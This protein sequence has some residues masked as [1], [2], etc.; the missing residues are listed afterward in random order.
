MDVVAWSWAQCLAAGA[1]GHQGV[2]LSAVRDNRP[3]WLP[4]SVE[5]ASARRSTAPLDRVLAGAPGQLVA[6]DGE[7]GIGKSRLLA[8]LAERAAAAGCVVVGAAASEFEDDLPYAVWTEA[9]DAHL[10]EL[11]D[12]R[13]GAARP[14]LSRARWRR[15]CPRSPG[16]SGVAGTADRHALHRALR[17]LLER[18]AGARP[19]VLWLDDVHWADPGSV[20][21]LAALVRR[22]PAGAVLIAVAAREGLQPAPVA[23]ALAG[24]ARDGRVSHLALAPLSEAEA[25]ELV[26]RDVG[27][28]LRA[29]RRQPVLPRAARASRTA[30]PGGA[31]GQPVA[32]A[33][34]AELAQLSPD[35]RLVLDAAAVIGDPFEPGARGG[36]RRRRGGGRAARARRPAGAHARAAGGLGAAVRVPPPGR[37]P[38]GL[39]GRAGRLAARRPRPRG[40]RARAP[41]RRRRRARAPRRARG[42]A[43]RRRRRR[44][45]GTAPRASCRARRPASAARFH[46]AALRI[47]PEGPE[48]RSPPGRDPGRARRGRERVRRPRGRARDAARRARRGADARASAA[49]SRCASPTRSSGS[50]ATRTRSAA[51]TSRSATFRRSRRRTASACTTRSGSTSCRRATSPAAARTRAT[52]SPMRWCSATTCSRRRRSGLDAM[53]AAAEADP[54][55]LRTHRP[56]AAAASPAS[57]TRSWPGA[58]PGCG[59]WRGPM[60]RSGGSRPRSRTCS[61]RRPRQWRPDASWCFS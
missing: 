45:A 26:G 2:H 53:G 17:D 52:R 13:A 15:S 55:A 44:A 57:T 14:R 33:I 6:V 4:W 54:S 28:D 25:A 19:L 38:R 20:D 23:A 49:R 16:S 5:S 8:E 41:R 50:G 35:T 21:A 27:G 9:L 39:R 11:G 10:R 32:L 36:R 43:R 22:P 46:A 29:E 56:R 61:A 51:S 7:P 40:R 58:C 3:P 24:A 30:A 47:L 59:C 37:P 18:L 1:S 42:P 60:A 12:R 34:A 31:P 48:H